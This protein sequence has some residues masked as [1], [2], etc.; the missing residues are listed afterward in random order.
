LRRTGRR[1]K[2]QVEVKVKVKSKIKA[3][4]KVEE[5]LE[6]FA[7]IAF[8]ELITFRVVKCKM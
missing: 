2:S 3:K 5:L 8:I 4:V 1:D 7:L 6:F